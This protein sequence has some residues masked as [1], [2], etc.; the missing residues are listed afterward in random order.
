MMFVFFSFFTFSRCLC[1]ETPEPTGA[2]RRNATIQDSRVLDVG[3]G[4]KPL[5]WD[6]RDAGYTG[7]ICGQ[8]C[9]FQ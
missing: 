3:C 4:D 6:L 5:A 7:K 9:C 2:T 8:V 1:G